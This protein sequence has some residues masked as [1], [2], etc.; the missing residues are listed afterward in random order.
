MSVGYAAQFV[1][2]PA[3]ATRVKCEYQADLELLLVHCVLTDA[4]VTGD[5]A[6]ND[7]SFDGYVL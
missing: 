5:K 2:Q 1:R 6:G 7:A 3:D 4:T